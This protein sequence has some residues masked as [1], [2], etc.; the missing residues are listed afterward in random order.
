MPRIKWYATIVILITG[1]L[2]VAAC[3]NTPSAPPSPTPSAATPTTV[4]TPTTTT[5]PTTPTPTAAP[6]AVTACPADAS[7]CAFAAT[8]HQQLAAGNVAGAV[9]ALRLQDFACPGPTP[10]GAGDAFPLCTGSTAGQHREGHLVAR[11][12][13]EGEVHSPA[14]YRDLLQ[15]WLTRI[16]PTAADAIGSGDLRLHTIGCPAGT[17]GAACKEYFS[18]TMSAIIRV[19][20]GQPVREL[21][22]FYVE[23]PAGAAPGIV[24]TVYG[25]VFPQDPVTASVRG[26]NAAVFEPQGFPDFG[27]FTLWPLPR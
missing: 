18:V 3:T 22:M 14:T 23:Q 21:L 1:L 13:S 12:Q 15:S 11:L 10:R 5:A 20:G 16:V 4:V 19:Q 17:A 27:S 6:P 25:V 2:G 24:M 8:L 26:G 7:I 9:A